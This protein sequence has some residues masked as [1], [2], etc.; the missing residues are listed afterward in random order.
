MFRRPRLIAPIALLVVA[1]AV[2]VWRRSEIAPTWQTLQ[3]SSPGWLVAGLGAAM[4]WLLVWTG[5]HVLVRRAVGVGSRD[6]SVPFVGV[7]LAA[8]A[9]NVVV[10][11][12]GMAGLSSFIADA[13]RRRL[14]DGRVHGAYVV[15]AAL[16]DVAFLFTL[17]VGMAAIAVDDVLTRNESLAALAVVVVLALKTLALLVIS[18]NQRLVRRA[19]AILPNVISR[20]KR[21]PRP[22]LDHHAADEAFEAMSVIRQRPTR[23]I[24]AMLCAL[25][26]DVVGVV[27]LWCAI[28]AV[29]GGD[30]I[31]VALIVYTVSSLFTVVSVLPGGVG[32]VEVGA[33]ATLVGFNLPL[34]T[35][36]AAV[37]IFR[38]YDFWLPLIF[39][40]FCAHRLTRF[41]VSGNGRADA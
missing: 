20:L 32:L 39:G 7:V 26:I 22:A 15:V 13:K 2:V 10:T 18:A 11:S 24:P 40:A 9:A 8:H 14:N 28:G 6:V 3:T 35:A 23:M 1:V 21:Q 33:A 36:A 5:V 19:Y 4:L 12:G 31:S 34:H 16:V 27:I 30:R 29:G 37:I 38:L 41:E 25:L 17:V